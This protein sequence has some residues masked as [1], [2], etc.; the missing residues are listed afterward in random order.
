MPKSVIQTLCLCLELSV[1]NNGFVLFHVPRNSLA[2]HLLSWAMRGAKRLAEGFALAKHSSEDY[3]RSGQNYFCSGYLSIYLSIWN[4]L[5]YAFNA[6]FL[7]TYMASWE[8]VQGCAWCHIVG[9]HLIYVSF[10]PLVD[11]F[12]GYRF[13]SLWIKRFSSFRKQNHCYTG[14]PKKPLHFIFTITL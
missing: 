7:R 13:T 10:F 2:S 6:W 4:W 8:K 1:S 11:A 9:N 14:V 5:K 12:Y 3:Y